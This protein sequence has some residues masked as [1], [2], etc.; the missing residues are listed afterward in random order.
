MLEVSGCLYQWD[1]VVHNHDFPCCRVL[2]VSVSRSCPAME[3]KAKQNK[4]MTSKGTNSWDLREFSVASDLDQA[5]QKV[6]KLLVSL[7]GLLESLVFSST[8]CCL[9]APVKPKNRGS[10]TSK[11]FL[12]TLSQCP[13]ASTKLLFLHPLTKWKKWRG[14]TVIKDLSDSHQLLKLQLL[15]E[16]CQVILCLA[17]WL[18][19]QHSLSFTGSS[20]YWVYLPGSVLTLL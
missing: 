15:N 7:W 4:L 12:E 5:S 2:C 6:V 10:R 13:Y 16:C 1:W 11:L 18:N 20:P 3:K 9:C 17:L 8:K 14:K 19:E